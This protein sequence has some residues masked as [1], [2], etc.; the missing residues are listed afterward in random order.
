MA[1]WN[2]DAIIDLIF[3]LLYAILLVLNI[4]NVFR[5]GFTKE[6]GYIFLVIVSLCTLSQASWL[7]IF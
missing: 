5:H 3:T 2:S 6:A 4:F 7:I 1:T